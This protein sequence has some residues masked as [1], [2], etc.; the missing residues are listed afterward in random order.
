MNAL[1]ITGK[2]NFMGK[3]IPVILGGFGADK[4]CISDK[5]IAEIHGMREP[6]VRRRIVDNVKRFTESVDFVDLAQRVDETHTLELLQS[7]GYAKQSITQAEHIYILSERGYAKLIKIMDTDK[8]WEVHDKLIDEY[9]VMKEQARTK[10]LTAMEHL[11]LQSQALME[12]DERTTIIEDKLERVEDKVD[13]QMT[14]D[15]GKQRTLQAVISKR[16]YEYAAAI[17]SASGVKNCTKL[18]F[19][20]IH[21]NIKDR[22]GVASYRDIRL[23]DYPEAL[24]YIKVW[25]EPD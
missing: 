22:F 20:A 10:A 13:N 25:I 8:A 24:R 5:T 16:V 15:H 3:D 1:K 18:L 12:L 19:S 9:F 4:K 7:L 2:Q 21:H 23:T 17:Y 6:D 11:R 14:I